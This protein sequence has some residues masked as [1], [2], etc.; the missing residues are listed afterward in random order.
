LA[1]GLFGAIPWEVMSFCFASF[2]LE[3]SLLHFD[4]ISD[5]T[6][7]K[8]AES[9]LNREGPPGLFKGPASTNGV[10]CTEVEKGNL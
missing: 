2:G 9:L 6:R 3:A 1:Q 7:S 8:V 10:L 4:G 5:V